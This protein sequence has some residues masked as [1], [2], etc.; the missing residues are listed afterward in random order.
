MAAGG[1]FGWPKIT[2]DHISRHFR[3]IRNFILFDIFLRRATFFLNVH[4]MATGGHFGWPKITFDRFSRHFRSI[5][6]FFFRILYTNGWLKITFGHISRHFRHIRNFISWGLFLQ[7]D[8][9]WPFWMTKITFDR[10]YRHFRSMRNLIFWGLF[11]QNDRRCP[12]WMI[13]NH[14]LSHLSPFQINAQL[15]FTKWPPAA[16]L[17]DRIS[18]SIALLTISDKYAAFLFSSFFYKMAASGHIGWPKITFDRISRHSRSILRFSFLI[19]FSKSIGTS[20][21]SMSVATSNIKL[22]GAF[23]IKL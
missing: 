2:F 8:R 23:L 22:I 20:L 7:N 17:V 1:H 4:K 16:I 9:R 10:I 18:L 3:S 12:F 5:C 21:Y 11:L 14:F 15:F 19:F 6:N 13:E